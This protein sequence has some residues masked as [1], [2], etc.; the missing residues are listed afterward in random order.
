MT[1]AVTKAMMMVTTTIGATSHATTAS[2]L[3]EGQPW[4]TPVPWGWM[5]VC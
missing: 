5:Q 2:G 4:L 1:K 3:L